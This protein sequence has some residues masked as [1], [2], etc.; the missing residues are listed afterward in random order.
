MVKFKIQMNRSKIEAIKKV[1]GGLETWF[2]LTSGINL[3]NMILFDKNK[4]LKK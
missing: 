4:A 2:K 1:D 3:T